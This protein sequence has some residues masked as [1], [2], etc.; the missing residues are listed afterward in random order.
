ML[1][2]VQSKIEKAIKAADAK[3]EVFE[4]QN[5]YPRREWLNN[6]NIY[7]AL[8][9]VKIEL[10]DEWKDNRYTLCSSKLTCGTFLWLAGELAKA[11]K[12]TL[13][14]LSIATLNSFED[15]EVRCCEI[16]GHIL[17][18][19]KDYKSSTYWLKRGLKL[20]KKHQ[21]RDLSQRLTL[22]LAETK[23]AS[24]DWADAAE[25]LQSMLDSITYKNESQRSL[26]S[27]YYQ[28]HLLLG[29]I[30]NKV[31][32]WENASSHYTIVQEY[33]DEE[34]GHHQNLSLK[35][36]KECLMHD[37]PEEGIGHFREVM[38]ESSITRWPSD[39]VASI[40][41]WLSAISDSSNSEVL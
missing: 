6:E 33:H 11:H 24:E 34:Y 36:G 31:G 4:L 10:K 32:D 8:Y 38:E 2:R 21:W 23:M 22:N 28:I 40:L 20:S 3:E 27:I 35:R 7:L 30:C 17:G 13:E 1:L 5:L 37:K 12:Y 41:G 14:S 9:L 29:D 25:V 19:R 16:L 39:I 18:E 26:G 15:L